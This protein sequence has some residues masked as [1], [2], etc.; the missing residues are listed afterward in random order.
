MRTTKVVGMTRVG[1]LSALLPSA[2][3]SVLAMSDIH[4][5]SPA[6]R[7][8]A[9]PLDGFLIMLHSASSKRAAQIGREQIEKH[10]QKTMTEALHGNLAPQR[11]AIVLS[12]VAGFQVMQ[13]MIGL[14]ALADA[15]PKRW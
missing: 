4:M 8:R 14:R 12:I 3:R 11:A 2:D 6:P 10:H 13:Q 1:T 9:N 7:K 15:D 5:K